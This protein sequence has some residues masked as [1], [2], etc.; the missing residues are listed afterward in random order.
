MILYK[1]P[2][3]NDV[4]AF[5]PIRFIKHL[6]Q[7]GWHPIILAPSNG[8]YLSYDFE[9]EKSIDDKC[10][11]YR[12]PMYFPIKES[13]AVK[14]SKPKSLKNF[15][16]RIWNKFA[17]PDGII[18]WLLPA[19]RAGIK[20]AQKNKVDLIFV[21]GPPFSTFIGARYIKRKIKK[22]L[23]VDF[24]DSW[25]FNP[26]ERNSLIRRW[27]DK[28]FEKFVL[29]SADAVIFATDELRLYEIEG[30]KISQTDH[31]FYTVTNCFERTEE[32][33]EI[34]DMGKNFVVIYAGNLY[35]NRNPEVLF[36][37]ISR[38]NSLNP[39]FA[40]DAKFI[41]YGIFHSKKL[42]KMCKSLGINSIVSFKPR[43]PQSQLFPKLEQASALLLIN[44][45]GPGHQIFIPAKFFDYLKAGRP[46][47]C[48]SERVAL[49]QIINKTQSGVII[50]PRNPHKVARGILNM[51]DQIHV[52]KAPL[53]I[54]EN[55]IT[56][57]ESYQT[58]K[59]LADICNKVISGGHTH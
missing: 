39:S 14:Y 51:Y 30:L 7:F 8:V 28:Q 55:R 10:T 33:K 38:A 12:I 46:I 13:D 26:F 45:Y 49:T 9:L 34:G 40:A 18:A 23:I 57:Y 29:R 25:A 50:D 22:K 48:L 44:S 35:G 16:W 31:N 20:I 54:D 3:S 47:I 56:E 17:F 58:T 24:R 37:G 21:S 2:P 19:I 6:N 52:R 53:S 27:F 41:F 11:I 42:D 43:I 5:R 1:F 36:R 15:I 59:Y 32:K 4:G